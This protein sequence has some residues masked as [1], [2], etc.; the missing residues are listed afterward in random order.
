MNIL[1]CL[2]LFKQNHFTI[3]KHKYAERYGNIEHQGIDYYRLHTILIGIELLY[4]YLLTLINRISV[5]IFA[6]R[7]EY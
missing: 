6:Q 3:P 1:K 2:K 4:Q 5:S 7:F